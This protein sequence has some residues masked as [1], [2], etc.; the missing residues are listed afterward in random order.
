MLGSKITQ[1]LLA[2]ITPVAIAAEIAIGGDLLLT[3]AMMSSMSLMSLYL[4]WG[5]LCALAGI[6]LGSVISILFTATGIPL[7]R[8]A[9]VAL[10]FPAG[11]GLHWLV[12]KELKDWKAEAQARIGL[13]VHDL[14]TPVNTISM[15]SEIIGRPY[16]KIDLVDISK[17]LKKA[18][19]AIN[20]IID[21]QMHEARLLNDEPTTFSANEVIQE[22][23]EEFSAIASPVTISLKLS[24]DRNLDGLRQPFKRALSCLIKNAIDY[25]RQHSKESGH[26]SIETTCVQTS[27]RI[28]IKDNG[29]GLKIK[30][31]LFKPFVTSR[32]QTHRGL[33]LYVAKH[34]LRDLMKGTVF[35]QPNSEGITA[36]AILPSND[37]H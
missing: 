21:E 1:L 23:F 10:A 14:R 29:G 13:T 31:P 22:T 17:K 24:A 18:T 7:E 6:A 4:S 8:I 3:M 27:L 19:G 32:P 28:D 12:Q 5:A 33:G 30:G 16:T 37:A 2:A 36:T 15:L 9:E 20:S 26:V 34:V 11:Y 25:A 35:L